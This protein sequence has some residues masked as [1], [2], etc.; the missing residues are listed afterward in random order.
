MGVTYIPDA[1]AQWFASPDIEIAKDDVAWRDGS[2]YYYTR[3]KARTFSLNCYFE[4][5]NM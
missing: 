5:V 2:Y 3:R 1:S 4:N